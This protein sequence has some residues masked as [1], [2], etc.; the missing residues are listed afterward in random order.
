[1]LERPGHTEAAVDLARLA[2]LNP[3]GVLVE[4]VN[5]DG[6]MARLPELRVFA[7]G[8]ASP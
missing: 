3:V 2:G 7:A 6:T 8:T 4:V 1:V 5:D